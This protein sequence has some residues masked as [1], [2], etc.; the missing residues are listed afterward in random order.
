MALIWVVQ[1]ASHSDNLESLN[2][3]SPMMELMGWFDELMAVVVVS[4]EF[5]ALLNCNVAIKQG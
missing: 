1:S 5:T 3:H 4:G 2:G